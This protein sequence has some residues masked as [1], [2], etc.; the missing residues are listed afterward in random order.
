[1]IDLSNPKFYY[2][3]EEV[4]AYISENQTTVEDLLQTLIHLVRIH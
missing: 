4:D 3:K 2:T 1:M